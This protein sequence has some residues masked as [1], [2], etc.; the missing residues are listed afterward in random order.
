[1]LGFRYSDYLLLLFT[2]DGHLTLLHVCFAQVVKVDTPDKSDKNICYLLRWPGGWK[3]Q[4]GTMTKFN[5]VS[6]PP[7]LLVR[8]VGVSVILT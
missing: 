8:A 3:L 2:S 6:R 4:S 7:V 5:T 1:M